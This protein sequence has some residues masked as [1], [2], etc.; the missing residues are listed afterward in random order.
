MTHTTKPDRN[1]VREY[2]QHRAHDP[3]PPPSPEEIRR[4][5]GW[6]LIESERES[7]ADDERN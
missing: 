7:R 2:F 1:V 3:E 4:Q 5:L 6:V